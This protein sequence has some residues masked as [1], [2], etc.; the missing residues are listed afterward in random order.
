MSRSSQHRQIINEFLRY[1]L[2]GGGAFILDI[3]VLYLTK[4]FIFYNMGHIGILLATALSFTCV[5][6]FN[7]IFSMIFVFK[8]IDEKAREN[9]VRSIIIFIVIGIAGL[10]LTEICMHTG[11]T[12]FGEEWYLAVKAVTSWIV[13]M[14]NYIGRKI[15]IFRGAGY[16][17]ETP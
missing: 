4:T 13:F 17:K 5:Q 10:L 12:V 1:L 15:F 6:I 11:I 8:Q 14:W 7:Y 16:M 3:T 9:K 2:V